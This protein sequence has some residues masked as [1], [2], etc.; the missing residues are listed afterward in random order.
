MRNAM[1]ELH[2]MKVGSWYEKKKAREAPEKRSRDDP[3][4]KK[5][6]TEV[7]EDDD[8][9]LKAS[10]RSKILKYIAQALRSLVERRFSRKMTL[11]L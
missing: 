4:E 5:K 11:F 6:R 1:R 10:G 8:K 3:D 2:D 7:E 9:L